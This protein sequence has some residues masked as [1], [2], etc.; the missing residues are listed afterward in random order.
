[1]DKDRCFIRDSSVSYKLIGD[2]LIIVDPYRHKLLRLNNV[3]RAIWELLDDSYSAS[4]I[5]TILKEEFEVEEK[6]LHKDVVHFLKE[7][8]KREMIR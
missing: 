5:I 8:L 1:M 4:Q 3:G 7:L 6:A 2:E